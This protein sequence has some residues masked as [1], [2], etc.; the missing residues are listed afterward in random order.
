MSYNRES[1]LGK[2]GVRT[3]NDN[4]E[5]LCD[6]CETNRLTVGG[7]LFQHKEIHKYTWK[8]PDGKTEIQIDHIIINNKWKRSLND[9]RVKRLADFGSNHHLLVAKVKLKLRKVRTGK[10][11]GR[12]FDCSKLQKPEVQRKFALKLANQFNALNNET[13]MTIDEFNCILRETSKRSWDIKRNGEKSGLAKQLG[14]KLRGEE[15]L[16]KEC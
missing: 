4:G 13:K 10:A 3:M 9:V 8:S 16:R 11:R 12:R 15:K 1:T 5:R 7:T 6:F 14:Q 2:H